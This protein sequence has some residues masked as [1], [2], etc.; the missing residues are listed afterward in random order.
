MEDVKKLLLVKILIALKNNYNIMLSWVIPKDFCCGL[1]CSGV[2][3]NLNTTTV[4][5]ARLVY[6]SLSLFFGILALIVKV[7]AQEIYSKLS[8]FMPNCNDMLCFSNYV[9]YAV[10][11]SLSIFHFLVL[12]FTLISTTLGNACYLKCWLLKFLLYFVLLL[13]CI[14]ATPL[15]V[16]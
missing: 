15:L 3:Q 6:I 4:L 12:I 5:H 2:L 16:P 8:F 13:I 7:F 1:I 10:M 9:T 11:M 14:L